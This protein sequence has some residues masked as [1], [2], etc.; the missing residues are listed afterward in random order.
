MKW[1]NLG[2]NELQWTK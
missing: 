2:I 1:H